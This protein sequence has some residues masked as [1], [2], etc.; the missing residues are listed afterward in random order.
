MPTQK[1][2]TT[3]PLSNPRVLPDERLDLRG[4][5]AEQHLRVVVLLQEQPEG[6]LAGKN[7]VAI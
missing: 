7:S 5:A 6:A 4:A 2:K 1:K 3:K